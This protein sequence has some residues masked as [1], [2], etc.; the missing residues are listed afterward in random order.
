[1][2]ECPGP[3]VK[4]QGPVRWRNSTGKGGKSG[5]H[6]CCPM[7]EPIRRYMIGVRENLKML[8]AIRWVGAVG[9]TQERGESNLV[10]DQNEPGKLKLGVI[11]NFAAASQFRIVLFQPLYALST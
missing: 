10:T 1:M 7:I 6:R 4:D 9:V 2:I 11:I 3:I 8:S 5:T